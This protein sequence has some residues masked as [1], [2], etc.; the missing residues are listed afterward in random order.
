MIKK[1]LLMDLASNV[2]FFMTM[3]SDHVISSVPTPHT[4]IGD[5]TLPALISLE[6]EVASLNREEA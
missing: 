6:V 3:L 5:S 2:S 4:T 1:L